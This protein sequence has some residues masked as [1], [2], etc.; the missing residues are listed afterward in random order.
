MSTHIS[1]YTFIFQK[2]PK[3]LAFFA[4]S[5]KIRQDLMPSKAVFPDPKG[6]Q[7]FHH[8]SIHFTDPQ[9]FFGPY[10][11]SA[12]ELLGSSRNVGG[13]PKPALSALSRGFRAPSFTIP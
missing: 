10:V 2:A 11:P 9:G 8:N 4:N 6:R 3:K 7:L 12:V 5:G 13:D 1:L